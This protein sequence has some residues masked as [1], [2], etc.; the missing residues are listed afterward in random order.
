MSLGGGGRAARHPFAVVGPEGVTVSHIWR[1]RKVVVARLRADV[2][3]FT[4]SAE[5]V[6]SDGAIGMLRWSPADLQ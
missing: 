2:D 5:L 4:V 1:E 6:A 3:K